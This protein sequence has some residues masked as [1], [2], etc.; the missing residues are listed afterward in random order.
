MTAAT[1]TQKPL[2]KWQTELDSYIFSGYQILYIQTSE[3]GRVE[4]DIH[5]VCKRNE[6][7]FVTWDVVQGFTGDIQGLGF[8][9]DEQ[10]ADPKRALN[11][12]A[13][14]VNK[15]NTVYVFRD[16]DDFYGANNVTRRQLQNIA[17]HGLLNR[18]ED[19]PIYQ[20]LI[21][22]SAAA[23]IP[24][25]LAPHVSPLEFSLP[26]DDDILKIIDF[27]LVSSGE[28]MEDSL[29]EQ[30]V[31]CLAGLTSN[32][33]ENC[34]ARALRLARGPNA[35]MLPIVKAEK[36][37]I[38]KKSDILTYIPE[39]SVGTAEHIGGY[40]ALYE[41]IEKR[42][43]CYSKAA[44]AAGLD[45]PKGIGLCGVPGVGKSVVAKI[46]CKMLNL[47]GYTMNIGAVFGSLVGESEQRIRDAIKQIEAQKGCVLV[48]D[49]IDK[50]LG[51]MANGS[52]DSGV[53][54]R[55]F[56]TLLTWLAE[57]TSPTFVVATLNRID[58]L[59]PELTRAGRFDA[60]FCVDIPDKAAREN[61]FRIHLSKRNRQ[62]SILELDTN[63]WTE[64]LD[65]TDQFVGAEIEAVVIDAQCASFTNRG[66]ASPNVAELLASAKTTIPMSKLQSKELEAMRE[67]QTSG[68]ARSVS[69]TP[70]VEPKARK[71]RVVNMNTLN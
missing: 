69:K 10:M 65:A 28:T 34:F 50:A 60:I 44:I 4:N 6:M 18:V 54:K 66:T 21:I 16:L 56:G 33:A 59:P 8:A 39:E 38:V 41:W 22:L 67:L 11:A 62:E 25:K 70:V 30:L 9:S 71:S 2:S 55:V 49:E 24:P 37:K 45:F 64:L 63:G 68:K 17:E 27:I 48:L 1:E 46:L 32:E 19:Q 29:K 20:V 14:G 36:A 51:G 47:P 61:I 5:D 43:S 3:E 23:N 53:G 57:K 13:A 31:R 40:E 42:K 7:R 52:G 35:G 12:I 58:D 15:N 26:D